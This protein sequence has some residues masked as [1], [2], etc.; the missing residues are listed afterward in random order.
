MTSHPFD[1]GTLLFGNEGVIGVVMGC[2]RCG[3]QYDRHWEVEIMSPAGT[4]KWWDEY[5]LW[6]IKDLVVNDPIR[7]ESG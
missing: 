7:E 3:H 4:V 5:E 6:R 2:Q 1:A